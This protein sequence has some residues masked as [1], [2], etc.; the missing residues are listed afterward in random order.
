ML[1]SGN[2]VTILL[3]IYLLSKRLTCLSYP[4]NLEVKSSVTVLLKIIN[5]Y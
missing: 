5:S 3:A 2:T 1:K 4:T